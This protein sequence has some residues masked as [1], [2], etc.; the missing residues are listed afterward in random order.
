MINNI[1]FFDLIFSRF[2]FLNLYVTW[3][4]RCYR[5]YRN[6]I[7]VIFRVFTNG[8]PIQAI[9]KNGKNVTIN[10][11]FE[12]TKDICGFN[13]SGDTLEIRNGIKLHGFRN[14]DFIDVF[15]NE[16]YGMI[17]VKDKVVIDVGAHICD[18]SI[19]FAL[20]GAKKV[21][22][23]EP[24]LANYELAKKNIETNKL[25]EIIDLKLGACSNKS[26]TVTVDGTGTGATI[27]DDTGIDVPS[28]SLKDISNDLDSAILKMDCECCEYD[29][30][31]DAD[32]TTLRKFTE[33]IIEYH[34]GYKNIARKLANNGF[35]VKNTRPLHKRS[36]LG[37]TFYLGYVH[38]VRE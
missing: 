22:A 32:K 36:W 7:Q 27:T 38:A 17:P 28:F 24:L 20:R 10:E 6:F 2:I 5:H 23:I 4:F 34:N 26:G 31:L 16:V 30:I 35:K 33:I 29:V 13:V 1:T 15:C 14:S 25:E 21:Y 37:E 9:L 8:Y 3:I 19:Y 12:V 11:R 18:S